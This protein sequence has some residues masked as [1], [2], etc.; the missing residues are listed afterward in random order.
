[1]LILSEF[2]SESINGTSMESN[3]GLIKRKHE[4][5]IVNIQRKL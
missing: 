2:E 5:G 1:M 3:Q 4:R